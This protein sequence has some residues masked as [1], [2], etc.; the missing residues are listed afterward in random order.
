M[1]DAVVVYLYISGFSI[2]IDTIIFSF[3]RFMLLQ[4]C[5]EESIKTKSEVCSGFCLLASFNL[6]NLNVITC[7]IFPEEMHK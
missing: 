4:N 2:F 7:K 1:S 6:E 5:F 3:L